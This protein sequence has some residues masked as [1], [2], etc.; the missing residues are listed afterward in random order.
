MADDE[1]ERFVRRY[2]LPDAA[3]T[4]LEGLVGSRTLVPVEFDPSVTLDFGP[5]DDR[6]AAEVPPEQLT[7]RY[8]DL[9]L[10]GTGGMSEVRRVRDAELN[11]VLAMKIADPVLAR[12][13]SALARFVD[14]AK[15]TAQLDHPGVVPV[16][17]LGRTAD[18]RLFF[19]MKEVRGRTLREVIT[20]V[21]GASPAGGWG[22]TSDGWNLH[23]LLDTWR[24]ICETVAHA[25][26]RGVVHRDLKPDNVMVGAY[27]EVL[28]LDWGLA[29]SRGTEGWDPDTEPV[30]TD[31]SASL[32]TRAGTLAGTPMYMSPEQAR[33]QLDR[34][35]ARSDVYALGVVLYEILYGSVPYPG[36][37]VA[38][39]VARVAHERLATPTAA[40]PFPEALLALWRGCTEPERDLRPADAGVLAERMRRF[41][42]GAE[43]R[44]RA[45]QLVA[46]ATAVLPEVQDLRQRAEAARSEAQRHAAGVQPW[47]PI[48]RKREAWAAEDE[49]ARLEQ[50]AE[51]EELRS[52]ELLRAALSQAPDLGEARAVLSDL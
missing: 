21:H 42:E 1:V 46:E 14:E 23:R 49:A 15:T 6:D 51:L 47:D 19:T 24:R 9:G 4:D 18:G 30:T 3:R 29:R 36:A 20:A 35:D 33:G 45:L 39:I 52:T 12:N 22:E 32:R 31:R 8:V 7:A 11:R 28:V 26:A 50:R 40:R 25:H 17:E 37:E 48:E 34:L 27:G 38:E 16:H 5:T 2:G 13:P 43:R 44:M 41:Q 10:L